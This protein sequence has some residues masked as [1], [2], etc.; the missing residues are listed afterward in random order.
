MGAM[1][2]VVSEVGAYGVGMVGDGAVSIMEGG[3]RSIRNGASKIQYAPC[4]NIG[5]AIWGR[6][7]VGDKAMDR[8][9]ADFITAHD[10]P[11]LSLR[12]ATDQLV[13]E[14]NR[15][16]LKSGLPWDHHRRGIH[17]AG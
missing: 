3:V 6:A 13:E 4:A 16:L 9:L 15:E 12:A 10:S 14:L 7:C 2:V 5:F 8:W 1:T 11:G 17:I